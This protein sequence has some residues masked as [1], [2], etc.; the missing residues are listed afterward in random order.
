MSRGVA[1][2]AALALAA[3]RAAAHGTGPAGAA[4]EA[5]AVWMAASAANLVMAATFLAIAAPLWKAIREGG[6]L[7]SNPLLTGFALIFTTCAV[8]HGVHFEHT[9]LPYYHDGLHAL[10]LMG[11]PAAYNYTAS[12]GLWSRVAMTHPALVATDLVTMGL[13]AWYFLL[14]K[15][16]NRFFEGAELAEDLEAQE[17]EARTMHDEVIEDVSQALLLV[18][19]GDEEEAAEV[20]GETIGNAQAIVDDLLETASLTELEPGDLAQEEVPERGPRD[21][22]GTEPG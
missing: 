18:D 10:P 7:W 4:P 21:P 14:R 12:F 6:Q 17:R 8:G 22:A 5:A 3:P 11:G 15:R 9:V 1:A 19:L 16:Q 20:V 13:G 2:A